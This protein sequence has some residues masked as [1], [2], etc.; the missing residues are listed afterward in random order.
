LGVL[1]RQTICTQVNNPGP[2]TQSK[3]VQH[4]PFVVAQFIIAKLPTRIVAQ[5]KQIIGAHTEFLSDY[6]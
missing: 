6:P 5:T 3:R 1:P 4:N 2:P